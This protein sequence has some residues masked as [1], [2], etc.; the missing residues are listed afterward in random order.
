MVKDRDQYCSKF[1]FCRAT[2]PKLFIINPDICAT[3]KTFVG[4]FHDPAKLEPFTLAKKPK[5][6]TKCHK[7]YPATRK[8]F[9]PSK[10]SR[11]GLGSW[12]KHCVNDSVQKKG[13]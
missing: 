7:P 2:K 4:I 13:Q 3:C 8:F 11:D 10:K 9:S 12:C 6:C 5:Y 1:Y